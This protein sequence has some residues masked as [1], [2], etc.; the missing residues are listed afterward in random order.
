MGDV[1]PINVVQGSRT[2][3]PTEKARRQAYFTDLDRPEEL[4]GYHAAFA[5]GVKNK[6]RLC[7]N[8]SRVPSP[9]TSIFVPQPTVA[10]SARSYS[11]EEW[12][13]KREAIAQLYRS[14]RRTLKDIQVILASKYD[15]RPS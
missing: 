8:S 14:N 6:P 1:G 11:Y 12:E 13:Q 3:R 4:P 5:A 9:M 7:C 2:G 10:L 15:F